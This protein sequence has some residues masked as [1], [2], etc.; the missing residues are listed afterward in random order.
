MALQYLVQALSLFSTPLHS[1]NQPLQPALWLEL[2]AIPA[3]SDQKAIVEWIGNIS[4]V[5]MRRIAAALI[6]LSCNPNSDILSVALTAVKNYATSC[7][8]ST[9]LRAN[10]INSDGSKYRGDITEEEAFLWFDEAMVSYRTIWAKSNFQRRHEAPYSLAEPPVVYSAIST[11]G[12]ET[13]L[14]RWLQS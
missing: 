1:T 14:F 9:A 12:N 4:H 13:S 11:I 3:R 5:M 7:R 6:F 10:P 8:L 2:K